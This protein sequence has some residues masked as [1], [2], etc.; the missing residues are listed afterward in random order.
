MQ[1]F[2][3]WRSRPG[4]DRHPAAAAAALALLLL[5]AL[6]DGAAVGQ[7]PSS[8]RSP[9]GP[10]A[11][12]ANPY[13]ASGAIP[14]SGAGLVVGYIPA[15]RGDPY[16]SLVSQG[17]REEAAIAGLTL[18]E[19]REPTAP[20]PRQCASELRR[21]GVE[22]VLDG[23]PDP[24]LSQ[25]VCGAHGDLATIGIDRPQPPCGV[26][27]AGVDQQEAGWLAGRAVGDA[28]AEERRCAYDA[29]V[30]LGGDGAG[31]AARADRLDGMA[32][33]LA[34]AC[35][36]VDAAGL[37]RIEPDPGGRS[38]RARLEDAFASVPAGGV[39][40]LLAS[41]DKAAREA[42]GIARDVG[43]VDSLRI[44]AIGASPPAWQDIACDPAWIAETALLPERYGMTV[45][46]AMVDLLKG[47]D[48]P[49]LLPTPLAVVDRDTIRATYPDIPA[50]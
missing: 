18:I 27:R 33:G 34:R 49:P 38:V 14:G 47:R 12:P 37:W 50:C 35:G 20:D 46:P 32:A 42:L 5:A 31:P 36:P 24:A 45:V 13:A 4:C 6:G 15:D 9:D 28:L 40:V 17:I 26:V 7:G 25:S 21:A 48:V 8:T 29:L 11:G 1:R 22:G 3:P 2:T 43:R 44:G 10:F 30:L 16:S 19:C 41:D 23:Q 39:M